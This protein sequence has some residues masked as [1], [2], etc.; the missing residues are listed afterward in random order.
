MSPAAHRPYCLSPHGRRI[1]T[2]TI[3]LHLTGIIVYVQEFAGFKRTQSHVRLTGLIVYAQDATVFI[4]I[5][6]HPLLA[7]IVHNE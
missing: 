4:R 7:G 2:Q 6:L 3:H 5:Q 1:H